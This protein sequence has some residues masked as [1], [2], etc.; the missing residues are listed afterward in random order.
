MFPRAVT[1]FLVA[2]AVGCGGATASHGD[3]AS[4][5]TGG[6][7][8]GGTSSNTTSTSA[9]GTNNTT[10]S[11]PNCPSLPCGGLSCPDGQLTVP[12]GACCPVCSCSLAECEPLDCPSGRT[13]TPAGA[14]CPQC[15][16]AQCEGVV[17]EGPTT[18]DSNSTFSRPAGACCAACLQLPGVG[19][20]LVACPEDLECPSGYVAGDLVG[21]CCYECLPDPLYCFDSGDCVLANRPRTCC[22]CEEAI[23]TRALEDDPCWVPAGEPWDIPAE[24]YPE[25]TCDALCGEC[26]DPGE[27]ACVDYRCTQIV[28][29]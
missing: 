1:L 16:E 17:C 26:P 11:T 21:G 15:A 5:G 2:T 7:A 3:D 20:A 10:G 24:C 22:G 13:L 18:C 4:G 6:D 29:Q 9:G 27:V 23:S 8:S 25:V 12:P 19:C 28:P 14:C